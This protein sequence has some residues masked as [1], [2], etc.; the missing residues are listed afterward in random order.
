MLTL[1]TEMLELYDKDF[2]VA[3]ERMFQRAITNLA[4]Q[5]KSQQEIEN[6]K[7]ENWK[8]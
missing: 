8:L 5:V 4:K 6:T 3:T 1:K 2:T 7:R